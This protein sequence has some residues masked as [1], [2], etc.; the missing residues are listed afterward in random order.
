[1]VSMGIGPLGAPNVIMK[2][3]FRFTLEISTPCGFIPRHY[4]KVAARPNLEIEETEL[5]FLNAVTWIPSKAKWQPINVIYYDVAG[6][7]D[8]QHL[9]DW[10]ATLYD[11]TK[12][13]E[14]KQAEKK[15]WN[16]TAL[17]TMYDGCGSPLERWLLG[18]VFPQSVNFGELGSD[19]SDI[20]TIELSLRYSEVQYQGVCGP[21][22][23]PC[24]CTGCG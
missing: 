10:L 13:T 17:L 1:M 21:T 2:R 5:S 14:L 22:P 11:F 6:T 19:D 12:P 23:Q 18:S 16:G 7:N 4:V 8:M 9:W 24:P 3:K 15:D 20:S